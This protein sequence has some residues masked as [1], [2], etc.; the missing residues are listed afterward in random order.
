MTVDADD[1]LSAVVDRLGLSTVQPDLPGLEKLYRTWCRNVPFDSA[2]KRIHLAA[3]EPEHP[4]GWRPDD[5]F[6]SWLADGTGGTCWS[7]SLALQALCERVGFASRV[8]VGTM[9]TDPT[10][11]P[12]HGSVIVESDGLH[13][14]DS[15][16]L[17]EAPLRLDPNA[18]T[19]NLDQVH[20]VS[21][22]PLPGAAW[23]ITWRPA[24]SDQLVECR[25]ETRRVGLGEWDHL[26]RRAT[27]YSLFNSALYVRRNLRD[28]IAAYG[29]GKLI[30]RDLA[31][32]LSRHRV[33][34]GDLAAT[35]VDTFGYSQRIT[36]LI[37]ADTQGP[38]FL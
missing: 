30:R 12:N 5:F 31:G 21:A 17:F 4:P 16:M 7:T 18:R 36:A 11:S 32:H 3:G 23:M 9:M 27:D 24:H 28:G 1:Q 19:E 15:S 10:V 13:L 2:M 29:R 33:P 6:T 38:A 20:P 8:A 25:V 37:P 35:L 14:V 26:H 22:R 34:R